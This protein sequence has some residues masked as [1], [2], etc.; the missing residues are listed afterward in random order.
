MRSDAFIRYG[1]DSIFGYPR[2]RVADIRR[3]HST[4]QCAF[5]E[6]R[7]TLRYRCGARGCS[8]SALSRCWPSGASRGKASR[9]LRLVDE[10]QWIF[11]SNWLAPAARSGPNFFRVPGKEAS[12]VAHI[13]TLAATVAVKA[14]HLPDGVRDHRT[15]CCCN[16]HNNCGA[17]AYEDGVEWTGP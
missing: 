15:V 3:A 13:V 5:S 7:T 4:C 16:R 8:C 2:S 17:H 14:V 1:S 12:F 10:S 9:L 6:L 11:T